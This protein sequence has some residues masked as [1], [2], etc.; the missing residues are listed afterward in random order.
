MKLRRFWCWLLTGHTWDKTN[1]N[2]MMSRTMNLC[3]NC[4][5]YEPGPD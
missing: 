4:G 5:A 2:R 1:S 3:R